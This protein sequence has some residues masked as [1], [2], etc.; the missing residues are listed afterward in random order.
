MLLETWL[1]QLKYWMVNLFP[2]GWQPVV[3]S[4]V[5][6][7]VIL[8]V[9]ATLF[10]VATLLERKGLGRIQNRPGPNRV[11]P[12]GLF[13]PVADG[14]KMLTKEDIVPRAADKV[15]HFLAP[16]VLLAPVTLAFAVIPFGRNL[17]PIDLDAGLLFFFAVGSAAEVAAFMAGWSSHNKYSLLG[18]M[19]AIAQM[20]SFELPLVISTVAVIMM[21]G[22]LSLVEI[23]RAQDG[24]V[25]GLIPRWHVLTPW[26]LA[27]FLIFFTA[28]LAESNRSPFDLPEGESEIIGG[29]MT[30]YSGFKYAIFF[31]GEYF[32]MFAVSGLAT[33]L[34]LGGWHAPLPFL[35]RTLVPS[36]VWFF[37]KLLL[38]LFVFIWL[39]GTLPRLRVD[40][41]MNFSWK[42]LLPLALINLVVVALWRFTASWPLAGRWALCLVALA[43][44][45]VA[46]GAALM[47][48]R[49]WKPRHYRYAR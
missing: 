28:A 22:S 46:L 35:D 33:T 6:V 40:Q 1:V 20:I 8:G 3:G 25:F 38:L 41:L 36:F 12:L 30:E 18:A 5:S 42:F 14:I 9:F 49:H 44:P 23:V 24:G 21:S 2:A 34:F 47:R 10:A 7:A 13:Q 32:G 11:G 48:Q 15:V 37:G 31:M 43:A 19:R 17:V 27:G 4:L 45:F 39:R 26:G 16:I 29:F